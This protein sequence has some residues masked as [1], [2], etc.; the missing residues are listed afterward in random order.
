MVVDILEIDNLLSSEEWGIATD[1]DIHHVPLGTSHP[2]DHQEIAPEAEDLRLQRRLP[3]QDD[4]LLQSVRAL[5]DFVENRKVAVDEGIE[6]GVEQERNAFIAQR[7]GVV[8]PPLGSL[9]HDR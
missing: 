2:T 9:G 7:G 4:R 1:Q 5:R 3:R 8:P 6:Y